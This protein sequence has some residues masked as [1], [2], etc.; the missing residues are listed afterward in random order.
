MG[1]KLLKKQPLPRV[2]GLS[3]TNHDINHDRVL[4]AED[5]LEAYEMLRSGRAAA[6]A[7]IST[8]PT[9]FYLPSPLGQLGH[10]FQTVDALTEYVEGSSAVY[11]L[12]LLPSINE[13]GERV[14]TG[15]NRYSA[16]TLAGH[17]VW[18]FG[19]ALYETVPE[20][21]TYKPYKFFPYKAVK[22]GCQAAMH[23]YDNSGDSRKIVYIHGNVYTKEVSLPELHLDEIVPS[24]RNGWQPKKRRNR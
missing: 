18:S 3:Y 12:L 11:G 9:R 20:Y 21:M 2:V 17:A 6:V 14:I 24:F 13:L 19:G 5:V 1:T 4:S 22:W 15:R 10:C 23:F 16:F 7:P 8:S